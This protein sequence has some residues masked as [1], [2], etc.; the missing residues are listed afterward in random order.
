MLTE[1]TPAAVAVNR[2]K[3]ADIE[4]PTLDQFGRDLTV[5]PGG[6][7]DPIIGRDKEIRKG[8]SDT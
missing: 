3:A 7:V 2:P 1:D 5:R 6:K 8:H 4:N